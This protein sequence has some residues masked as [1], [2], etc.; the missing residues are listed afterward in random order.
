VVID[1]RWRKGRVLMFRM[2]WLTANFAPLT[3]PGRQG[4]VMV[5]NNVL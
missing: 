4:H 5:V 3:F 2:T 1:L